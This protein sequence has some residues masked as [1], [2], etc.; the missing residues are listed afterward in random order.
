MQGEVDE[1][2]GASVG[3]GVDESLSDGSELCSWP[4]GEDPSLLLQVGAAAPDIRAAVDLGEGYRVA[5]I[6]GM[7]GPAAV[8]TEAS[9]SEQTVTILGMNVGEKSIIVSP[10]GLGLQAGSPRFERL[11]ELL[12]VV[13]QRM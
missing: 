1:L 4:A 7:S 13:A 6:P 10:V 3:A 12:G 11:K 8:T 5:E 2:F 9:D